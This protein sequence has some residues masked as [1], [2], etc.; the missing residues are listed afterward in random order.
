MEV[1]LFY[2]L[3]T[4][5]SRYCDSGAVVALVAPHGDDVAGTG[6]LGENDKVGKPFATLAV[7]VRGRGMGV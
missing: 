5:Y 3:T 7:A 4:L 1:S 2:R 6:A